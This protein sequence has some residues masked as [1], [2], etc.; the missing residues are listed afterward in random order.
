MMSVSDREMEHG[1][2]EVSKGIRQNTLQKLPLVFE[3]LVLLVL[4]QLLHHATSSERMR[5]LSRLQADQRF[6]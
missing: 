1:S 2:V 3:S 4:I 5:P 6:R